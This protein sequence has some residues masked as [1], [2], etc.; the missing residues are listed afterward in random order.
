MHVFICMTITVAMC[1]SVGFL[2]DKL[3]INIIRIPNLEDVNVYENAT[4]IIGEVDRLYHH[5]IMVTS[6]HVPLGQR[7]VDV[8]S[9]DSKCRELPH[10]R[11]NLNFTH[12]SNLTI[13]YTHLYLFSESLIQYKIVPV[14]SSETVN[15]DMKGHIYITKGS[16]IELFSPLTCQIPSPDCAVVD[17]KSFNGT[18]LFRSIKIKSDETGYYNVHILINSDYIF[19]VNISTSAINSNVT[20]HKCSINQENSSCNI[21]LPF[22]T[23]SRKICLVAYTGHSNST[24]F[25]LYATLESNVSRLWTKW[26]LLITLLPLTVFWIVV[27]IIYFFYCTVCKIKH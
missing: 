21:E 16:E 20:E 7:K 17:K 10:K 9:H 25:P 18:A 6:V 4:V 19:E 8:Y 24:D 23:R 2:F 12:R 11:S 5:Q 22:G 13:N 3:W 1:L 15:E 14:S 27:C 26:V